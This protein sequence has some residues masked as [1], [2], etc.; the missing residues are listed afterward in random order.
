[1]HIRRVFCVPY[2]FCDNVQ[3][4][5]DTAIVSGNCSA[6][7]DAVSLQYT[8]TEGPVSVHVQ[9]QVSHTRVYVDVTCACDAHVYPFCLSVQRDKFMKRRATNYW[10]RRTWQRFLWCMW[11]TTPLP[12]ISSQILRIL[13]LNFFPF[14]FQFPMWDW[15][16][17]G[18]CWVSS[19]RLPFPSVLSEDLCSFLLPGCVLQFC[20]LI[21]IAVPPVA[22]DVLCP[23]Q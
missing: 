21:I 17:D 10:N 14:F 13:L 1:M 4:V 8:C 2:T 5:A 12:F 9:Q 20:F 15:L 16:W 6:V 23:L 19:F 3:Q 11:N 7:W 18:R 22:R